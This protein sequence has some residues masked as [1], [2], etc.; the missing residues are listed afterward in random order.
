MI[1]GPGKVV[2]IYNPSYSG[3]RNQEDDSRPAQ[4]KIR[5]PISTTS[6][7]MADACDTTGV[8]KRKIV[9]QGQLQAKA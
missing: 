7:M 4:R 1:W 8:I 9:V 2:H 3:G 5:D 6:Q